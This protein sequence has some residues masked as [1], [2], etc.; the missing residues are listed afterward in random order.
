MQKQHFF[1][2]LRYSQTQHTGRKRD[3]L[4]FTDAWQHGFILRYIFCIFL[5]EWSIFR[6]DGLEA[7]KKKKS[8][9]ATSRI[10]D[11]WIF[12]LSQGMQ[13]HAYRL[14]D[15]WAGLTF[16]MWHCT[17]PS[18]AILLV[19]K[20]LSV[21]LFKSIFTFLQCIYLLFLCVR[22]DPLTATHTQKK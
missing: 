15:F 21:R 13:V 7:E 4:L 16:D 8:F 20:G 2:T 19:Q 6:E 22:W 11:I 3:L 5:V 18:L 12:I 9:L 14:H 1:L 17:I 10:L